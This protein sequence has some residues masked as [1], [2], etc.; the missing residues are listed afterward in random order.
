MD[1]GVG[2][3]KWGVTQDT[4]AHESAAV[5]RLPGLLLGLGALLLLAAGLGTG[6]AALHDWVLAQDR[7]LIAQGTAVLSLPGVTGSTDDP[8]LSITTQLSVGTDPAAAGDVSPML[9]LPEPTPEPAAQPEPVQIRIPA[10]G[11]AR[12]IIPV[13]RVR[14]GETGGW[15][16]NV[17][18]LIR[19]GRRDLVGHLAGSANPG[20]EGNTILAGHNF[21]YGVNGVFVRLGR[22]KPGQEVR[23]VNEEGRT[24]TY[25]V[26]EVEHVKWRGNRLEQLAKHWAYLAFDGPERLTLITCGGADIEPFPERIYVVAEPVASRSANTP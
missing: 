12:S 24:F 1:K 7:Y 3:A 18:R 23:V 5:R 26:V 2:R 10:I 21:G 19:Q 25:E 17:D 6:Y 8:R 15:T 11:V 20:E 13:P 9:P 14:N 4:P 22:L 16:W